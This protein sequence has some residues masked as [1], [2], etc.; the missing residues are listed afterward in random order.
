MINLHWNKIKIKGGLRIADALTH[1]TNLK[2]LDLSWN[3]M[4]KINSTFAG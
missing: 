4:G 2:V 1:N 3:A